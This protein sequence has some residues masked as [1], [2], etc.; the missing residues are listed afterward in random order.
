MWNHLLASS[1][2]AHRWYTDNTWGHN[3]YTHKDWGIIGLEQRLGCSLL[4]VPSIFISSL[5]ISYWS[6]LLLSLVPVRPL[7]PYFPRRL[8]CSAITH[9]M[10]SYMACPSNNEI[11]RLT[12]RNFWTSKDKILASLSIFVYICW[13]YRGRKFLPCPKGDRHWFEK[14]KE[15]AATSCQDSIHT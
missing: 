12:H 14:R 8:G 11:W 6:Y 7:I 3:T 2:T 4:F 5:R 1:G 9:R 13:S 10:P 15:D